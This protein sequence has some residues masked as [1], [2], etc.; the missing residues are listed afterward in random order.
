M[1]TRT[2]KL[3]PLDPRTMAAL[4]EYRIGRNTIAVDTM[5][6]GAIYQAENVSQEL[7]ELVCM[8]R[9]CRGNPDLKDLFQES[10]EKL[11]SVSGI[12]VAID[13][14]SF[15]DQLNFAMRYARKAEPPR[16][17]AV[18][19]AWRHLTSGMSFHNH[20]TGET[21][22]FKNPSKED[23]QSMAEHFFGAEITSRTLDDD[24]A[25]MGLEGFK[26]R[27]RGKPRKAG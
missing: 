24:L 23:L 22:T 20:L 9:H 21:R 2:E 12:A 18:F 15:P 14:E 13:D 11:E 26:K 10:L 8:I 27:P 16:R 17:L 4:V 7:V 3:T 19:K 1:R 25:A 6:A 5:E